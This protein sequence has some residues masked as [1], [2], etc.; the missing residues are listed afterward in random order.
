MSTERDT[1][2][3]VKEVAEY[4]RVNQRTVYRLAV[5]GRLPSFKVGATWRFKR[6]DIDGWI[7]AQVGV[8]PRGTPA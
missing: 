4:L 3:T 1:I 8:E 7:S 2:M 6:S 5:D